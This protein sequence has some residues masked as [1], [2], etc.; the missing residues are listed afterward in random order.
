MKKMMMAA[1]FA[2]IAAAAFGW[3]PENCMIRNRLCGE[4]ASDRLC[5]KFDISCTEQLFGIMRTKRAFGAKLC[6]FSIL[7]PAAI[8]ITTESAQMSSFISSKTSPKN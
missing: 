7:T 2:A 6:N 1:L 5:D 3:L 4:D 8:E